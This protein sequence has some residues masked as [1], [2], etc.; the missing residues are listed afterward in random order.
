MGGQATF[1]T[2]VPLIP[3][4]LHAHIVGTEVGEFQFH[5]FYE[6]YENDILERQIYEIQDLRQWEVLLLIWGAAMTIDNVL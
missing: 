1:A 2:S 6:W 3:A 5:E 4:E